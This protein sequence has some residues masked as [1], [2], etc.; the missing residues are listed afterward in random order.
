[1]NARRGWVSFEGGNTFTSDPT[2]RGIEPSKSYRLTSLL[3]S[4]NG[5]GGS[6]LETVP[7]LWKD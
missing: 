3:V 4:S 2:C 5:M 1:M 6:E 7:D